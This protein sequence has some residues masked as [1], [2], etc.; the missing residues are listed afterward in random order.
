MRNTLGGTLGGCVESSEIRRFLG[1]YNAICGTEYQVTCW[2]DEETRDAPAIDAVAESPG[3]QPL[4]LEHTRL[5]TF[6]GQIGLAVAFAKHIR[7]VEQELAGAHPFN[8]QIS[9]PITVLERGRDWT[10]A[11]VTIRDWF[12]RA[13]PDIPLGYSRHK[14]TDDLELSVRKQDWDPRIVRILPEAP[15]EATEALLAASV[16][17]RL[18]HKYAEL[19]THKREGA[20]TLLLL[21]SGDY[22]LV[23]EHIIG[24]AVE[25]SLHEQPHPELDQIWLVW[26]LDSHVWAHCLVGPAAIRQA[27]LAY[28]LESLGE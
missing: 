1:S 18:D 9:V 12:L 22:F 11:G 26:F 6:P 23:N 15:P 21:E 20:L 24:Q 25:A 5:E 17:R 8:V 3:R 13:A 28:Q 16:A 14:V 2:P 4:A 27:A 10:A 7:P 19:A